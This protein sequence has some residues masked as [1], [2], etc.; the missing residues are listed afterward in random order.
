[1]EKI[2]LLALIAGFFVVSC[3]NSTTKKIEV[4]D[5][6][7]AIDIKKDTAKTLSENRGGEVPIPKFSSAE[8]QKLAEDYTKYI[9]E[10]IAVAKSGDVVKLKELA[11]KRQ[12]WATKETE[13]VSKFTPEDAKLWKAYAENLGKA[14]TASLTK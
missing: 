14:L 12:E 1:M 2:T 8:T 13:A 10:F 6:T 9:K 5:T 4:K 7:A 3:N 11:S